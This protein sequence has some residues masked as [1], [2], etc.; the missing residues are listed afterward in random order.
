MSYGVRIGGHI[1]V[2][3][4]I[5]TL[6]SRG[7]RITAY[8][9]LTACLIYG[10]IMLEASLEWVYTFYKHGTLTHGLDRFGVARWHV[11]IIVPIGFTLFIIRYLEVGY[12][13]IKGQQD[14]LGMA[15]EAKEALDEFLEEEKK[16]QNN[17][18]TE[19]K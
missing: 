8:I 18:A 5:N 12:R 4:L 9:G 11:T 7:R 3:V 1:G 14:T 6:S 15:D 10:F 13:L 16:N 19:Q 17:S 2:D